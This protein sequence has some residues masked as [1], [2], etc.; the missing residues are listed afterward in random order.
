MRRLTHGRMDGNGLSNTKLLS[1]VVLSGKATRSVLALLFG[2]VLPFA[3][4]GAGCS[5]DPV[6]YEI[7][8]GGAGGSSE[9]IA[10]NRPDLL[11]RCG[12]NGIAC[13]DGCC[14]PNNTCQFDRC[15]P[16]TQC[17]SSAQ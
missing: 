11:E 5:Q 7:P 15:V 1:N 13:A 2:P 3:V 16:V 4:L 6:G 17:T 14:G 8:Q 9:P 10:S 12:D